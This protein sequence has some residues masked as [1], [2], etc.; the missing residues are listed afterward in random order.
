MRGH[1]G[2]FWLLAT[3]FT[4]L[5]FVSSTEPKHPDPKHPDPKHP[6]KDKSGFIKTCGKN[7]TLDGE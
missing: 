4:S 6:D 1:V 7:F 5:G 2:L 3:I